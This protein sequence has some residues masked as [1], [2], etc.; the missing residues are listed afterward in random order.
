[1]ATAVKQFH[2]EEAIGKTYDWKV[3]RR[4]FR[5]LK[6]YVRALLPALG[7]TLVLN[8]LGI[9]QPMFTKWA[10]DW[11]IIPAQMDPGKLG[12]LNWAVDFHL[13]PAH[14]D[15]NLISGLKWLALVFL[16]VKL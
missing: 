11:Y 4:L 5:Y 14:A 3:A 9:M 12:I 6:P 8:L 16:G 13:I 10:I 2:E 7:L 1:M 15:P